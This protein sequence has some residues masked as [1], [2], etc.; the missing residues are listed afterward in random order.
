ME[1]EALASLHFAVNDLRHEWVASR[2]V[3]DRMIALIDHADHADSETRFAHRSKALSQVSRAAYRYSRAVE[4][5]MWPC[6]SAYTVLGITLLDRVVSGHGP[7]EAHTVHALSG[8]PTVAELQAALSIPVAGLQRARFSSAQESAQEH[9]DEVLSAVEG[10]YQDLADSARD[11]PL[12]RVQAAA[13]RLTEADDPGI[14]PLWEG[15]LEP[16]AFL[17][18]QNTLE[19]GYYLD[20]RD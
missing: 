3:V 9:Q 5:A 20:H 11:K 10:L 15:L 14:D 6:V 2:A 19:I 1:Y 4:T 8:E 18:E 13:C 16:L 17:A 7:L 12:D